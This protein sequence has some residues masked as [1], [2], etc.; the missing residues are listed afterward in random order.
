MRVLAVEVSDVSDGERFYP[1]GYFPSAEEADKAIDLFVSENSHPPNW[2][3]SED[4]SNSIE[5]E[6]HW[7]C[8]GWEDRRIIKTRRWV[9]EYDEKSDK[10]IWRECN[11]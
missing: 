11:V 9:N 5:L 3:E 8:K 6:L 10:H 1:L 2:D 4:V 7:L